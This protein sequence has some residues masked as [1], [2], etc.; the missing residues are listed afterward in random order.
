MFKH[1]DYVYTVYLEK[2]FTKAAEKLYISQ[3]ALSATV[4]KLEKDLGFPI[5]ERKGKEISLI[6][7]SDTVDNL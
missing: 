4:K 6:D 7:I 1:M 2:S 3:P 5:F